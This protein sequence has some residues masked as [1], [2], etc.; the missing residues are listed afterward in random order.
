MAEGKFRKD[1]YFRLSAHQV[2]VPPLRARKKDLPLLFDHF[3]TEAAAT[4][5]KRKPALPPELYSYL[6]AYHFP[7]NIRELRSM[8][9]DA[10]ARHKR[11]VLSMSVF[12]NQIGQHATSVECSPETFEFYWPNGLSGRLPTLKEA[13]NHLIVE[14]LA[15][16]KGNQG[17]AASFL[18]ISRQA[19]NQ[20]LARMHADRVGG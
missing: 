17:A 7:G 6:A 20:R 10:M 13:E 1:L 19:L 5:L 9:F 11:G 3:L 4:F 14:A 15:R 8:I 18:G 2:D 16:A 12:R